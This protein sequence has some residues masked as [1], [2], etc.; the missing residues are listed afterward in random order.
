[1]ETEPCF[2]RQSQVGVAVAST[3]FWAPPVISLSDLVWRSFLP[4]LTLFSHLSNPCLPRPVQSR[5]WVSLGFIPKGGSQW[6]LGAPW[7]QSWSSMCHGPPCWGLWGGW[8]GSRGQCQAVSRCLGA[9]Q[10]DWAERVWAGLGSSWTRVAHCTLP[11]PLPIAEWEA[12]STRSSWDVWLLRTQD[13]KQQCAG[14]HLTIHPGRGGRSS[15]LYCFLVSV[16]GRYTHRGQML[17]KQDVTDLRGRE[18]SWSSPLLE[19]F[20][21]QNPVMQTTSETQETNV[22]IL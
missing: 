15:E 5:L 11:Q 6:G 4:F 20:H 12:S 3:C 18:R 21:Y 8:R 17:S 16:L 14:K 1:M 10:E 13:W 7:V 9:R 22:C 19:H 2:R